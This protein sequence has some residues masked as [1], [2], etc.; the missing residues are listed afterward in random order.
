MAPLAWM[1]NSWLALYRRLAQAP[2]ERNADTAKL[3]GDFL[4][5]GASTADIY[6]NL[7][8][9]DHLVVLVRSMGGKVK[10]LHHFHEDS[11]RRGAHAVS[12]RWWPAPVYPPDSGPLLP[13][14]PRT[15][16]PDKGRLEVSVQAATQRSVHRPQVDDSVKFCTS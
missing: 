4:P 14:P 12:L 9:E 16:T 6:T 5:V 10:I 13:P 7:T 11:R 15:D 1:A 3:Y 8:S 2:A